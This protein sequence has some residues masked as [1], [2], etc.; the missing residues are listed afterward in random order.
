MRVHLKR[1]VGDPVQASGVAAL[2]Y[3]CELGFD[4]LHACLHVYDCFG[5]VEK[6]TIARPGLSLAS[7]IFRFYGLCF[8]PHKRPQ[9]LPVVVGIV[10]EL[11]FKLTDDGYRVLKRIL[12]SLEGPGVGR[13]G[14][15]GRCKL[16][17]RGARW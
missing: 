12:P 10:T 17:Q 3:S 4:L 9:F 8:L 13:F 2:A 7:W 16:R 15:H 6:A 11:L 14:R 1:I 5:R